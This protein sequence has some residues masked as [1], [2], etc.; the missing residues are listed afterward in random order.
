[1]WNYMTS[2]VRHRELMVKRAGE[3]GTSHTG[4]G[5]GEVRK[6]MIKKVIILVV[7]LAVV[8]TLAG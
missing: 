5:L 6:G 2:S 4:N 7:L 1:M 3:G 8:L